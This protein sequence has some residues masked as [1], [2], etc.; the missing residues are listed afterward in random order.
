MGRRP[1]GEVA[2]RFGVGFA[3]DIAVGR[4]RQS[5][6][7]DSVPRGLWRRRAAEGSRATDRIEQPTPRVSQARVKGSEH[8]TTVYGAEQISVSGSVHA[9]RIIPAATL[10]QALLGHDTAD[11]PQGVTFIA[12]LNGC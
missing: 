9:T 2:R 7:R 6:A 11:E 10:R 12:A 1:A 8:P 5:S 4:R 3:G